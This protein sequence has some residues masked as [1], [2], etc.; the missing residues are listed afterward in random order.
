[1]IIKININLINKK[2]DYNKKNENY[3]NNLRPEMIP[4]YP[5]NGK[6]VLDVGCGNGIFAKHLKETKNIEAWGLEMSEKNA[7]LA[8]QVLD[9]VLIGTCEDKIDELPNNYFDAIY[10]NDILEHIYNP[11]E[12]LERI[13]IKLKDD[14]VIISSIPNVRYHDVLF[15]YLLKKKWEYQESGVLDF[16]HL[17]FYTKHSITNL[18]KKS[19]YDVIVNEG[20]NKTKSIRP[21]IFN[22]FIGFTAMDIF[23]LQFA[24]V[25][26]KNKT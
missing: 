6:N 24:T 1:M 9:K 3:F 10:F 2:V 11:Q 17:K 13:K 7:I 8:S 5:K 14:G 21:Y 20:I 23:Y 18:Y 4:F 25:V 26:K 16:T 15:N 22:F 12:V 19:G